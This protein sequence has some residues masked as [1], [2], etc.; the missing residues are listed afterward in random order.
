MATGRLPLIVGALAVLGAGTSIVPV[1]APADAQYN[2]TRS[3]MNYRAASRAAA[4]AA[5]LRR[6]C[7]AHPKAA[8]CA[9]LKAKKAR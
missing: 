6:Y 2:R 9:A 1:A 3:T 5:E 7:R 4:R 8:R